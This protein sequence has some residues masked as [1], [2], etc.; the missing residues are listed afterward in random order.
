MKGEEKHSVFD[1]TS[2][3]ID[4]SV[5]TEENGDPTT[6]V[7]LAEEELVLVDL[8]TETWP[9]ML[10]QTYKFLKMVQPEY[11]VNHR[12][13]SCGGMGQIIPLKSPGKGVPPQPPPRG[14][15]DYPCFGCS[16]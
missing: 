1:L 12:N 2:K 4:F 11:Q 5:I 13:H 14:Y 15:S 16:T 10:F 7:I 6:L 8:T 9:V 3:V